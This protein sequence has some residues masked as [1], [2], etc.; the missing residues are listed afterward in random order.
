LGQ[1]HFAV[2]ILPDGNMILQQKTEKHRSARIPYS[3]AFYETL[4]LFTGA[5][6]FFAPNFG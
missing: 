6:R 1:A 5:E 3:L 4:M 2:L